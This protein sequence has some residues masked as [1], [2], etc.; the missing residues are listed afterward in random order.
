MDE[1]T[2]SSIL[3]FSRRKIAE[4]KPVKTHRYLFAKLKE[5]D[6][7]FYRGIHG[8][9]GVGKTIML[10]QLA[11][12]KQ[13]ALYI[14]A[15]A[16][17][18]VKYSIYEIATYARDKG[19]T[20]LFIDEIQ[21]RPDWTVD[22][23][24]LYDQGGLSIF[25]TG[26]SSFELRK[27]ADLSRRAIIYELKPA[28]F[29]EYLNIKRGANI[30]PIGIKELF[31]EKSRKEAAF[32]NSKWKIYLE[33]YMQYGGVLYDGENED[34]LK[35]AENSID[36]IVTVDLACLRSI[37]V[38]I[39]NDIYKILFEIASS[40]PYETNY[41]NLANSLGLNK[42]TVIKLVEDLEKVG[43]L[44]IL[45]PCGGKQQKEPKIYIRPPFRYV[46][47]QMR[48][49]PLNIG[50]VREEFLVNHTDSVC[51]FKTTRGEKTPDFNVE[52]KIIEVGGANK[53]FAKADYL[54]L[55]GLA[56][57]ENKI[58]LFLFGFL[59]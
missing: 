2:F 59:Y 55:D 1:N 30:E 45:L 29:R 33:E 43:L 58:P 31:N 5:S 27:G 49:I 46:L 24:T 13:N 10:L 17:Q 6:G 22:L 9:R 25:F 28:S 50:V 53:K 44:R 38:K 40:G 41:S 34:L 32:A 23:K 37:D 16:K 19:Y 54:A 51:Y 11:A 12:E 4:T 3:E 35:A 48:K 36:K 18:L 39:E 15:D 47:N 7:N 56:S 52:G 42:S 20:N 26:S 21:T 8:L 14:P 57:S